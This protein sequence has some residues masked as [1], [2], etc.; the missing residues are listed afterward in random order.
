MAD[1]STATAAV[2][3]DSRR[4]DPKVSNALMMATYLVGGVGVALGIYGLAS[5]GGP[6]AVH[7]ALPLVVGAVGVLSMV[8]H[9]VFHVSDARRMGV[10]T[11]PF[12]MIELGFANGAIGVLGLLAFFGE[13]GVAAETAIMFTYA[14]YLGSAFFLALARSMSK[15]IDGGRAFGL[16]MWAVQVAL[17]FYFAVAASIQAGLTPF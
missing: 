1:D 3:G 7:Y 11:E 5:G 10:E 13:W 4:D 8:R 16:I 9:S 6:K 2:S 14:L 15:G 12:F 17:M